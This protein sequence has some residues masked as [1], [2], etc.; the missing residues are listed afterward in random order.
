M[1]TYSLQ[2]NGQKQKNKKTKD[3][4]PFSIMCQCYSAI[5]VVAYSCHVWYVR[6]DLFNI[7]HKL[8]P[9]FATVIVQIVT[10]CATVHAIK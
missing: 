4:V 6:S 7:S 3:Y 1:S 10:L 9:D 8:I 5:F 2:N